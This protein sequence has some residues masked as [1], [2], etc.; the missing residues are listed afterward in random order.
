MSG[1]SDRSAAM[2]H[3]LK[4]EM[5]PAVANGVSTVWLVQVTFCGPELS[6][7]S[8]ALPAA[9]VMPTTGIVIGPFGG[10]V[11]TAAFSAPAALLYR[12]TPMAPAFCAFHAL[13]EN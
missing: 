12:M 4:S 1:L 6:S 5:R 2:P 9:C 11:P 10:T 8:I 13:I 7:V 3:E